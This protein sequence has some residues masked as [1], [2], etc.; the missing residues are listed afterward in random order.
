MTNDIKSQ[1]LGA[2]S[3]GEYPH[4][5]KGQW[6]AGQ[7]T[8]HHG[9]NIVV[10]YD[11]SYSAY[12]IDLTALVDFKSFVSANWAGDNDQI[13]IDMDS[14]EMLETCDEHLDRIGVY[15]TTV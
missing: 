2:K 4:F 12:F 1:V 9:G 6:K 7:P 8:P 5:H 10:E 3:W 13:L 14:G 15:I 11:G